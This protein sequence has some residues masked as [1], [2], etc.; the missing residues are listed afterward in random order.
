[1]QIT[2]LYDQPGGYPRTCDKICDVTI[3]FIIGSY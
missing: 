2:F 1:L 3:S